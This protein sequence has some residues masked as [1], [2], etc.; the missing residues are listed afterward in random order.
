MPTH[1]ASGKE[2]SKSQVKKLQKLY[3]AQEKKYNEYLKSVPET[4]N[5]ETKGASGGGDVDQ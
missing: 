5:T 4:D 1:D 3:D 2:L